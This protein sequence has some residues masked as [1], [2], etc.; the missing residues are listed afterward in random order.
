MSDIRDLVLFILTGRDA[1]VVRA[2]RDPQP[3][4]ADDTDAWR[5]FE[6]TE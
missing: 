6:P 5:G 4:P 2:M 1:D 3:R